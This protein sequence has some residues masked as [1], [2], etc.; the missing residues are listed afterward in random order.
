MKAH[1]KQNRKWLTIFTASVLLAPVIMVSCSKNDNIPIDTQSINNEKLFGEFELFDRMIVN[2][3]NGEPQKEDNLTILGNELAL[4]SD[5]SFASTTDM[6]GNILSG[7]WQSG[8]DKLK[9]MFE[10]GIE[11][12]FKIL[13][14]KDDAIE[15][16]QE[17]KSQRKLFQW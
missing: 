4:K 2:S 3:Q 10:N 14:I 9:L 6:E 12:N 17:F 11:H 13:E 1:L 5:G 8:N 15:L 7:F 16:E